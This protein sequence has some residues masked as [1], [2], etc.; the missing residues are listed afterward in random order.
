MDVDI[1]LVQ[2]NDRNPDAVLLENMHDALVGIGT[3]GHHDPVAVYSK[4]KIIEKLCADGFSQ[5]DAE[6]Y[7]SKFS[8]LWAAENTPVILDDIL[9]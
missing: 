7:F 1:V 2:L 5:E 9:E 6:E 3:V 4:R 8:N